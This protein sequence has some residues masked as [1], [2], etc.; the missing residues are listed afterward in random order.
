MCKHKQ[1]EVIKQSSTG[2]KEEKTKYVE[3]RNKPKRLTENPKIGIRNRLPKNVFLTYE[4]AMFKEVIHQHKQMSKTSYFC[5]R[6][7]LRKRCERPSY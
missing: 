6:D 2:T 1:N 3:I 4:K 5:A 7:K